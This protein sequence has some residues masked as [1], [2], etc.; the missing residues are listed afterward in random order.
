MSHN[1]YVVSGDDYKETRRLRI[2]AT[3]AD[4][5]VDLTGVELTFRVSR[6]RYDETA[7][8]EKTVGDGIEIASPQTDETKGVAYIEVDASDTDDLEGKYRWELEGTD[9][10]GVITLGAG[11]F[12]VTADLV[13]P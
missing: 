3:D 9:S 11:G 6:G 13:T 8:F 12:Y 5:A 4:G 10:V 1:I 7:V 2:A